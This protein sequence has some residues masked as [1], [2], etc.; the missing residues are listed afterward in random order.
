MDSAPHV[1]IAT[2]SSLTF[3]HLI[4]NHVNQDVGS[5]PARAVT[6]NRRRE[7]E[8]LPTLGEQ[9]QQSQQPSPSSFSS[10]AG[11]GRETAC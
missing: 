2:P 3:G 6:V 7:S 5:T 9:A 11:R 1:A 4:E 8:R 10:G